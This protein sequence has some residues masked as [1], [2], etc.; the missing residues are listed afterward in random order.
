MKIDGIDASQI[1][2]SYLDNS[3]SIDMNIDGSVTPVPF[4]YVATTDVLIARS[5]IYIIDANPTPVQFGGI[6]ALTN[7]LLIQVLDASLNALK[8]FS[9]QEPIV[10]NAD[11]VGLAGTD[12]SFA[13]G[14]GTDSVAVRW[15]MNRMTGGPGMILRAGHRFRVLVRDDLTGITTFHWTIQG[16]FL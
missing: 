1:L 12:V 4:D 10:S 5:N 6:A 9:A 3:S 8:T 11:F 15:T 13:I 14:A 16:R 7:G 2:D